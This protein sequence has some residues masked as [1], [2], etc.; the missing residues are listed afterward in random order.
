MGFFPRWNTACLAFGGELPHNVVVNMMHG[1]SQGFKQ[2]PLSSLNC[3]QSVW[4]GSRPTLSKGGAKFH[5]SFP[6]LSSPL[7]GF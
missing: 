6:S 4:E 1:G 7:Q 3:L 2:T 5:L